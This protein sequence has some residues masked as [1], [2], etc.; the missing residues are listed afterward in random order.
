MPRA[1]RKQ[2]ISITAAATAFHLPEK[3]VSRIAR[4]YKLQSF[5]PEGMDKRCT[6]YLR[7]QLERIIK[8]WLM[9]AS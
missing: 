3:Q 7:A 6:W 5:Q 8:A 4:A 1:Y 9:L 2:L